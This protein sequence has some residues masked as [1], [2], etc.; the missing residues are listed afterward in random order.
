MG[1]GDII[2]NS[3][4]NPT[5]LELIEGGAYITVFDLF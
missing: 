2:V 3:D 4:K 5:L 1:S